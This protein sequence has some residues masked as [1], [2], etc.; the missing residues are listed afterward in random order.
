[1]VKINIIKQVNITY[2]MIYFYFKYKPIEL[3]NI[4]KKLKK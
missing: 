4:K 3:I 2:L 1:M